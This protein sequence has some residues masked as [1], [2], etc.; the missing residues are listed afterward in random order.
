[1]VKQPTLRHPRRVRHRLHGKRR[2][3]LVSSKFRRAIEKIAAHDLRLLLA[4]MCICHNNKHTGWLVSFQE[5]CEGSHRVEI[6][7]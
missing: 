2:N 1:M 5:N 6:H 3:T 4:F 7:T